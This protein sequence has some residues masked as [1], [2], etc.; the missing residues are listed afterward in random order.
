[1]GAD[2]G[3]IYYDEDS[4][5]PTQT[6]FAWSITEAGSLGSSDRRFKTN[7]NSLVFDNI[8]GIYEKLNIVTFNKK[9]MYDKVHEK[10]RYNKKKRRYENLRYGVIAQEIKKIKEIEHM[11]VNV[12]EQS[13]E[14]YLSINY[15]NF[16]LL[17]VMGIQELNKKYNEISEKLNE[18]SFLLDKE[19]N[20]ITDIMTN[21]V[22][23]NQNL[24]AENIDYD[25]LKNNYVKLDDKFNKLFKMYKDDIRDLNET[26]LSLQSKCNDIENKN[27]IL[28]IK[29]K[30]IE[31][32]IA[33]MTL[34]DIEDSVDKIDRLQKSKQTISDKVKSAMSKKK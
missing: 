20:N 32:I 4:L 29:I 33:S 13:D 10:T 8:L 16:S 15:S 5:N 18:H 2:S 17:N 23:L 19:H 11:F 7:I 1:M 31:N 24:E 30:K 6:V 21:S 22:N 25:N 34:R 28:E 12:N 27:N 14:K 26:N 3:L 9:C